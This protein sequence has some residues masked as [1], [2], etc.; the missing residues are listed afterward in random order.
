MIAPLPFIE[1]NI[2]ISNRLFLCSRF[3]RSFF[4]FVL[5]FLILLLL[6]QN[7][8]SATI[9]VVLPSA[10]EKFTYTQQEVAVSQDYRDRRIARDFPPWR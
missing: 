1:M 8:A 7:R 5:F 6:L 2:V 3:F 9:Y 10:C 4:C